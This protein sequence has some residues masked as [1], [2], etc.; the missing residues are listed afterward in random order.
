MLAG[1]KEIF[2]SRTF[3]RDE[4]TGNY[5]LELLDRQPGPGLLSYKGFLM[6]VDRQALVSELYSSVQDTWPFRLAQFETFIFQSGS[7]PADAL[8]VYGVALKRVN[9]RYLVFHRSSQAAC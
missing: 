8:Y 7:M 6:S 5:V 4:P 9:G 3:E 1:G 2:F